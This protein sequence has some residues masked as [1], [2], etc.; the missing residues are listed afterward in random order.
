ME[1]S[2]II[3]NVF[4]VLV[5]ISL[6]LIGSGGSILS[7]PIFTY[8]MGIEPVLATAYSL[9]AVGS[10]AL[11]GGIQKAKQNLVDFKKVFLFGVP[12][13]IAVFT[14]RK[15]IVPAI[16][17]LIF[18]N[19]LFSLHKSVLIMLVFAMVMILA[20]VRMIK[21]IE[22]M[23]LISE[24]KLNYRAIF[25]QGLVI[26]LV[27]GFVGAGGGFLIIP[28]LLLLAKTPMK[29]AIGTSLFIVAFQSL[30]GFLGDVSSNAAIEWKLL[31]MF[32]FCSIIGVIIG[33]IFSKKVTPSKL[34][35]GF[36][37][38]VLVMGIYIIIKEV[39]LK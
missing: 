18:D 22:E 27:A 30:I 25:F 5:G 29:K 36:G 24:E 23:E 39:F 28:A 12:T 8:I 4:A 3:G 34:K 1:T 10:T 14:T 21:P 35:T 26:G 9:F 37:Y 13:V 7:V 33:N 32:T 11:F 16:P 2:L 31:L 38:F 15:F 20:A 6:G 19:D 17:D